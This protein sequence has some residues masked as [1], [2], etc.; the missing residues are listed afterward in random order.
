[1]QT[2]L[3]RSAESVAVEHSLP[4][5]QAFEDGPN[6]WVLWVEM[7]A[8]YSLASLARSWR[9]GRVSPE[10]MMEFGGARM[11]FRQLCL[12]VSWLKSELGLLP[13]TAAP[14]RRSWLDERKF[15]REAW[16]K[17]VE[18]GE[19]GPAILAERI[20]RLSQELERCKSQ[21]FDA[22]ASIELARNRE[23]RLVEAIAAGAE[24]A[25]EL[26][27]IF[28]ACANSSIMLSS[29]MTACS[30]QFLILERLVENLRCA[31]AEGADGSTQGLREPDSNRIGQVALFYRESTE[32]IEMLRQQLKTERKNW[33]NE[34]DN[35]KKEIG[36]AFRKSKRH[37][38]EMATEASHQ[39]EAQIQYYRQSAALYMRW[40]EAVGKAFID[41]QG[42]GNRYIIGSPASRRK[43]WVSRAI[44][45]YAKMVSP[46][47]VFAIFRGGVLCGARL[48]LLVA[49]DGLHWKLERNGSA[50]FMP[51]GWNGELT[52]KRGIIW[53]ATIRLDSGEK[54][55]TI[56]SAGPEGE[57]EKFIEKINEANEMIPPPNVL[58]TT[59]KA[60]RSI[61]LLFA[62]ALG[63]LQLGKAVY[64]S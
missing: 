16:R 49:S 57:L 51:W 18:N 12:N 31:L 2:P 30:G 22:E 41:G 48:G 54:L 20:E 53:G 40:V 42:I 7:G 21:L 46:D 5:Q 37:L 44:F 43:D 14:V 50:G 10:A 6:M 17:V 52:I 32:K 45:S 58:K 60:L 9:E 36:E 4:P 47:S 56:L 28:N 38:Q 55:G 13:D 64:K 8:E 34:L 25:R 27:T 39:L 62:R 29:G 61:P 26:A 3:D 1:M 33:I 11:T 15:R 35:R 24:D 23:E 19:L 63:R 59:P